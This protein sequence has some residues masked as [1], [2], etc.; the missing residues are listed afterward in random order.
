NNNKVM[1]MNN[2]QKSISYQM[3]VINTIEKQI[4][5]FVENSKQKYPNLIN[6]DIKNVTKWVFL[7]G[8]KEDKNQIFLILEQIQ[9]HN[10]TIR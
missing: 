5:G 7:N 10:L 6:H 8:D 2:E 3:N 1:A 9:K 4:K